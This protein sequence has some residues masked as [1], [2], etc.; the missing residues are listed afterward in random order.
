MVGIA[1]FTAK[2][3]ELLW[4]VKP[5]SSAK[6]MLKTCANGSSEMVSN[7]AVAI[8]TYLFNIIMMQK[9]GSDGVAAMTIVFYA[10]FLFTAVFFGYTSGVA[11]LFSFH[12]G[13]QNE[14][15]LQRLFRSSLWFFIVCSIAACLASILL[16][17]QVVGIFAQSESDVFE[18][19]SHGMNLF[20]IGFLFMGL[21]I[22]AS[23]L[24]TALSNG[25]VSAILSFL[26]TFVFIVLAIYLLPKWLEV[27]GI[28][29]AIPVAEF[30]A[31][32]VAVWYMV[33]LRPHYRY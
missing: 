13:A 15:Q 22:F 24:F 30:L 31:L 33:R 23:G 9:L 10:Q 2:R 29:L 32:L 16:A 14:K 7:L 4:F 11:P 27:N 21:N 18:L 25:K 6:T 19:A 1:Y 3:N 5:V 17:K 12:Y 8:T 26:R 28:W 20:A